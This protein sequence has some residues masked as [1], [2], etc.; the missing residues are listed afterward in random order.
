MLEPAA[1]F[2]QGPN[3]IAQPQQVAPEQIE[4]LDLRLRHGAGEHLRFHRFDFLLNGFEHGGVVVD[5]EVEDGVENVILTPGQRPRAAF[6]SFAHRLVGRRGAVPDRH[7]ISFA[8]EQM[9]LAERDAVALEL[10]GARDDE[11]RV[12]ILLDLRPLMGMVGIFDRK[13]MQLELSLH[14]AQHGE[15]G[16]MESDPDHVVGLAAPARGFIDR[17]VGDTPAF[18]VDAGCD[19]AAGGGRLGLHDA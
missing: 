14:A 16:F 3:R 19:H 17:D 8:D 1:D 10:R 9:R 4:P 6:A 18:D 13:V 11:Q 5:D 7:D 12:A 2:H 15:I